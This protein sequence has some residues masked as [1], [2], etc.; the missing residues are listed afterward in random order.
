MEFGVWSWIWDESWELGVGSLEFRQLEFGVWC[1]EL[2]LGRVVGVGSLEFGVWSVDSWSLEFGVWS[3][4]GGRLETFTRKLFQLRRRRRVPHN[5]SVAP[6]QEVHG[7]RLRRG[8]R[9]RVDHILVTC[10]DSK[11]RRSYTSW[12]FSVE[13]LE[14]RDWCLELDLG[15]VVR[16]GSFQ[17]RVWSF[18]IGV[19]S[20]IWDESWELGV[21]SL[22]F[23]QLEFGVWCS[24]LDLGRVVGVGS[25]EFG[26]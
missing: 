24:E 12:E 20:W 10:R 13:S 16:V 7:V 8:M 15:R 23:R 9:R 18:E 25:L 22:E 6:N 2:D 5:F 17:L 3:Y 14:F 21:G 26:V 11:G 19:W 4:S 1:S